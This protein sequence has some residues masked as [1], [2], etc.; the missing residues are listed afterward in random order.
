[1]GPA[2]VAGK[3]DCAVKARE[4]GK[5]M[6]QSSLFSFF[7]FFFLFFVYVHH[8]TLSIEMRLSLFSVRGSRRWSGDFDR[9]FTRESL[10]PSV[11]AWEKRH[12]SSINIFAIFATSILIAWFFSLPIPLLWCYAIFLCVR[13]CFQPRYPSLVALNEITRILRDYRAI[14]IVLYDIIVFGWLLVALQFSI[15]IISITICKLDFTH[16]EPFYT[17]PLIFPPSIIVCCIVF[18]YI[19]HLSLLH[20]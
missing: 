16:V 3:D 20:F 5:W 7:F 11:R 6:L 8:R 17:W 19:L 12:L 15:L 10:I 18:F 4:D 2:V 9:I 14:A 13:W 1:M